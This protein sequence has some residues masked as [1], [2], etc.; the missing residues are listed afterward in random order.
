MKNETSWE[1]EHTD[2]FAG[3]AN[4][5][6]VRRYQI[7]GTGRQTIIRRAKKACGLTGVRCR[8]TDFGDMFE[9]RPQGICQIVFVT[10]HEGIT[11]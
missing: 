11:T 6:W 8:V 4:Y 10:Y 2:T 7:K 9:I 1:V 3:E 5:C